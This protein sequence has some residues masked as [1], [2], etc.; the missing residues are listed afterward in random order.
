VLEKKKAGDV[1]MMSPLYY[2]SIQK[3]I[4]IIA[5]R[6]NGMKEL[7]TEQQS[8]KRFFCQSWLE[9]EEEF[10]K[11][12]IDPQHEN[13]VVCFLYYALAKRF[14]KKRF[15]LNFIRTEDTRNFEDGQMRPDLNLNDRVFIEV[16]IYSLRNY[17]QGWKRRQQS[18]EHNVDKLKQYVAHQK[19]NSSVRVRH[20]ILAIWFRKLGAKKDADKSYTLEDRFITEDLEGKLEKEKNRYKKDA[21]LLYGPR[22]S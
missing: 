21:T 22:R 8:Y 4:G 19:S 6:E 12:N 16:K 18:I 1:R 9:L 10:R 7:E 5:E 17:G 13:D 3:L 14:K 20:P 11:G 2:G 15:P